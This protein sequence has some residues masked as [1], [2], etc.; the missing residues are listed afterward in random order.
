MFPVELGHSTIACGEDILSVA[1]VRDVSERKKAQRYL[2][3]HYAATC[4]LADIRANGYRCGTPLG[5]ET[6]GLMTGLAGIGYGLLRVAEPQRVPAV[7]VLAP[8]GPRVGE[9]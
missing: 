4:I 2:A 1:F 5:V 6:P 8:P 9:G 7:L 3:A